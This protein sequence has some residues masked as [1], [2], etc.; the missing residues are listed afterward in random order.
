M[1]SNKKNMDHLTPRQKELV[2]LI[3]GFLRYCDQK[4]AGKEDVEGFEG[5][6][7]LIGPPEAFYRPSKEWNKLP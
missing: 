2:E 3:V 6:G 4:D 1:K 5:G 7:V